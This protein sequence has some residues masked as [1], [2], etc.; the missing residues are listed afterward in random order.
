M[1]N[2]SIDYQWGNSFS[3]SRCYTWKVERLLR[4][5]NL[6]YM[7]LCTLFRI[8]SIQHI[9]CDIF[10]I[11][12]F[13]FILSLFI[14]PLFL[15]LLLNVIQLATWIVNDDDYFCSQYQFFRFNFS[16]FSP[17]ALS[18]FLWSNLYMYN[19]IFFSHSADDRAL[20]SA[21]FFLTFYL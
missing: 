12:F 4:T 9:L 11:F 18:F 6:L 13:F 10:V 7:A 2:D 16:F 8:D 15:S 19:N 21:N 3:F 1:Y 17:F 20:S 5:M 14:I